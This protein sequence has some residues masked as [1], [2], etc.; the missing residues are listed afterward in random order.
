[1]GRS[2]VEEELLLCMCHA[3]LGD[4]AAARAAFARAIAMTGAGTSA[5]TEGLLAAARSELAAMANEGGA[6]KTGS[7]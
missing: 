5:S 7:R 4:E 2:R 1:M 6:G 3:R